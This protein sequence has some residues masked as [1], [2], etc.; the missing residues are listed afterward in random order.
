MALFLMESL[1]YLICLYVIGAKVGHIYCKTEYPIVLK[2]LKSAIIQLREY[3]LL[4]AMGRIIYH[5]HSST[6]T[7]ADESMKKCTTLT[8]LR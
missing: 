3:G 1:P 2:R 7:A 8:W 5:Y 4:G 6:M